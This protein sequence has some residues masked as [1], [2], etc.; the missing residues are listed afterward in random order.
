ML[1]NLSIL[2]VY[3]QLE[4]YLKNSLMGYYLGTLMH[5]NDGG[6]VRLLF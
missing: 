3:I 1:D 6:T 2:N 4:T 5:A